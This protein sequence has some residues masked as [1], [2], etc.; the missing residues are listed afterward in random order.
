MISG[1]GELYEIIPRET[2]L[3]T[4]IVPFWLALPL[5]DREPHMSPSSEVTGNVLAGWVICT[6]HSILNPGC[7]LREELVLTLSALSPRLSRDRFG[8][9][10]TTL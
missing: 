1:S 9:S 6:E 3:C 8:D 10:H 7:T 2:V 4:E 5:G